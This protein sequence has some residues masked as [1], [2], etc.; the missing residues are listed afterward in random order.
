MAAQPEVLVQRA[1]ANDAEALTSLLETFG[2]EVRR[3]LEGAVPRRW[4]ALL[5][6]DDLMQE[7]Y[8][9]AFLNIGRFEW[10]GEGS[11]T[12]WLCTLARHAMQDAVRML[13]ADKRGGHL[14]RVAS[15]APD[16]S[17]ASLMAMLTGS[18]TSPGSRAERDEAC[19]AIRGALD[20]LPL[21]Y[22]QVVE[23]YDLE[24]RKAEEVAGTLNRSVGA[25]FM[26]R[27]RAHRRLQEI[28][29]SASRYAAG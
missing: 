10:R 15:V 26:L 3:Q 29:G 22:R 11:F 21:T 2:P 25:M 28:L 1:V 5:S 17:Y 18:G 14:H 9:S 16:E 20:A 19:A 7:A 8:T 23:A 4:R 6:L 27:S 12:A 13:E 24:G